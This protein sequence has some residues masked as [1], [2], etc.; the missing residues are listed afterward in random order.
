[1]LELP[2]KGCLEVCSLALAIPLQRREA[3]G[4]SV[5]LV[6]KEVAVGRESCNVLILPLLLVRAVC[7]K[8]FQLTL[9][10]ALGFL[11]REGKL[12]LH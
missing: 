12:I 10:N 11:Y 6:L 1:V 2:A 3:E 8:V 5:S 4:E 9:E 7:L